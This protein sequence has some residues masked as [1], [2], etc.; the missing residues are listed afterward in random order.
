MSDER[1]PKKDK[2]LDYARERRDKAWSSD[3]SD[4]K[5]RA[6]A[7]AM[8]HRAER[9]EASQRLGIDPA[10]V[11]E[12]DPEEL[13]QEVGKR[14]PKRHALEKISV[15]LAEHVEQQQAR[16]KAQREAAAETAGRPADDETP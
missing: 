16:R 13:E 6:Q 10:P 11:A 8:E 2:A 3:K 15:P 9:R 7:K 4:R 14:A 12:L 5:K 1:D